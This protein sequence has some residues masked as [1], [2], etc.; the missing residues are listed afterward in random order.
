MDIVTFVVKKRGEFQVNLHKPFYNF[1]SVLKKNRWRSS[2]EKQ[3]PLL[4]KL[5]P[6][7]TGVG[8]LRKQILFCLAD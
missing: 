4:I 6:A 3:V 5:I 1:R 7:H 2:Q 8:P